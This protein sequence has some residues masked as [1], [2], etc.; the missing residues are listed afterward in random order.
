M[1][2]SAAPPGG[3]WP[4]LYA[5]KGQFDRALEALGNLPSCNQEG[6]GLRADILRRMGDLNG[7]AGW[8]R[9]PSP[10]SWPRWTTPSPALPPPRRA[11]GLREEAERLEQQIRRLK[12]LSRTRRPGGLLLR[13]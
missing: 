10:P 7:A 11:Q 2:S 3:C 5:D 12:E 9:P 8:R 13:M 1:R 4:A 6:L